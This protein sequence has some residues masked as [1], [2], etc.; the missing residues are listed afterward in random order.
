MSSNKIGLIIQG[1]L[2]GLTNLVVSPNM[3]SL[4]ESPSVKSSLLDERNEVAQ[5][6]RNTQLFSVESNAQ[7]QIFSI[8]LTDKLDAFKRAGY[9]AIRL[10]FPNG[11]V[12][13]QPIA[14][15]LNQL[16]DKYE[17]ISKNNI[18]SF[19]LHASQF[20]D[21][22]NAIPT[23]TVPT[24]VSLGI[25][26]K[27]YVQFDINSED[28]SQKI[29]Q[30]PAKSYFS[31]IYFVANTLAANLIQ[32]GFIEVSGLTFSKLT[33][34]GMFQLVDKITIQNQVVAFN[35]ND[36]SLLLN[37][38]PSDQVVIDYK[39]GRNEVVPA[40]KGFHNIT[41]KP[42]PSPRPM[43][44]QQKSSAKKSNNNIFFLGGLA[45]VLGLGLYFFWLNE[46][47]KTN[48]SDTSQAEIPNKPEEMDTLVVENLLN[49]DSV[50]NQIE[51][52]L[53]GDVLEWTVV[54]KS[55]NPFVWKNSDKDLEGIIK[56][57]MYLGK[58]G[59]WKP[60]TTNKNLINTEASELN[61]IYQKFKLD[62]LIIEEKLNKIYVNNQGMTNEKTIV[63]EKKKKYLTPSNQ[64]GKKNNKS[65]ESNGVSDPKFKI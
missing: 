53:N 33:I 25:K 44:G 4:L 1:T 23:S 12:T 30:L 11:V 34:N 35:K 10:Y 14:E 45:A 9:V 24:S 17:E 46:K 32:N 57:R 13:K 36:F 39:D 60:N 16:K 52:K 31:K 50:F 27:A 5:Y 43:P 7:L 28:I 65:E 63:T 2:S 38:M 54:D 64:E 18:G 19:E 47:S 49:K 62:K 55:N 40:Q 37:V 58:I 6:V 59:I 21:I 20:F 29:Q 22:V 15:I 61:K 51:Y 56:F 42:K 48:P 8:I 26:K 41:Q 3:T